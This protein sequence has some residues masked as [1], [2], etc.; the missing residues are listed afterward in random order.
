MA[1]IVLEPHKQ[2]LTVNGKN[3][4]ITIP[5]GVENGQTIKI[6]GH[7]GDGVNGGP[8]GDLYISFVIENKT[9]FN[10]CFNSEIPPLGYVQQ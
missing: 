4:R 8:K 1:D 3:I 7:G 9:K 10:F 2:T 5:E 6:S